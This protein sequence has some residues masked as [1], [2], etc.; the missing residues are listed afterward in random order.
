MSLVVARARRASAREWRADGLEAALWLTAATALAFFVASGGVLTTAPIDYLYSLGRASGI[1][2]AVL[3]LNQVML[4]SRVP[5]VERV[6]GHDRAAALHM[7]MGKVAIILMLVHASL[8]LMMTAR[9]DGNPVWSQAVALWDLGWFMAAA[10]AALGLFAVVFATSLLIVRRRWRYESWHA[11][12][13]IVY[14]AIALAVPHQ[15]LEGS[16][17]RTHDAARWFWLVLYVLA[18][19]CLLAFRVARPLLRLRRHDLRVA[20]VRTEP[21]GS[22][23]VTV[24]GRNLDRLN[25]LPGQFFLWRFLDRDR[26]REA[27]PYSLSRAPQDSALRITAKPS[28]DHSASLRHLAIGERVLVEG[29]LGVFTDVVRHGGRVVF[30]CAGVGITPIRAMLETLPADVDDCHVIVRVRTL[31]DAPLLAEVRD[32]AARRGADVH[33]LAG[34]RGVGWAPAGRA[35]SLAD[36]VPALTDTDVYICGPQPWADVVEADARACGVPVAFIHRERFGW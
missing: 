24:V 18:F 34:G 19:G 14:A 15:F 13:L 21:D 10:Q 17:F 6:L 25:A 8:L 30:V 29:P 11:V 12:H 5:A 23:S 35:A 2:A 16:T 26:W 31:D 22:T 4:I 7:R 27:H 9:Y 20:D 3:V 33:V 36:L 1:V 28:G 32:I